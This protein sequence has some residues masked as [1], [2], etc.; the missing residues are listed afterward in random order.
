MNGVNGVA[1]LKTLV[2]NQVDGRGPSVQT[3]LRQIRESVFGGIHMVFSGIIQK[4]RATVAHEHPTWK[5]AELFGASISNVVKK[6]VTHV[7]AKEPG[8]DKTM[9]AT[10]LGIYNCSKLWLE[11]SISTFQRCPEM[12]YAFKPLETLRQSQGYPT[13]GSG[14]FIAPPQRCVHPTQGTQGRNGR[15]V[16]SGGGGNSQHKGKGGEEEDVGLSMAAW[17]EENTRLLQEKKKDKEHE[18][19]DSDDDCAIDS[20]MSSYL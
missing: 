6:G 20:L 10:K 19:Y 8:T 12:D 16:N 13:A 18:E 4:N 2:A 7:V 3:I 15:N 9:T 1:S 5:Q 14:V 17:R 11:R